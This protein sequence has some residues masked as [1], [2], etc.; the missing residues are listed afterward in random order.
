MDP[1]M[2][3]T[4]PEEF[5]HRGLPRFVGRRSQGLRSSFSWWMRLVANRV[6]MRATGGSK[7]NA[8]FSDRT[9]GTR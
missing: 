1:P 8:D 2:T 4:Q 7:E 9:K 3:P 5:F 6:A